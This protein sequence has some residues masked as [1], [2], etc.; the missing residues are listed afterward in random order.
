MET[1]RIGGA[2]YCPRG[3]LRIIH[4]HLGA[5]SGLKSNIAPC[6]KVPGAEMGQPP[7][8]TTPEGSILEQRNGDATLQSRILVHSYP[9]AANSPCRP[10]SGRLKSKPPA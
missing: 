2:T 3:R 1:A 4:V 7:Y 6:M 9:C 8:E 5:L 10:H